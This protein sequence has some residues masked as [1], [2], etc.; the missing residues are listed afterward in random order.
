MNDILRDFP[1][2]VELKK[3]I[4]HTSQTVWKREITEKEIDRWLDNFTG[5]ILSIDEERVLALWLLSN[6]VYYNEDEVRHLCTV[7]MKDFVHRMLINVDTRH[8]EIDKKLSE[9][10]SKTRFLLLGKPSESGGYILYYF[11]TI[12]DLHISY[13]NPPQSSD[14]DLIDNLVFIDDVTL[15]AGTGGQAYKQLKKYTESYNVEGQRN[16]PL[17]VKRIPHLGPN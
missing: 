5:E 11:R 7:L 2:I 9:L 10:I 6:F 3:L 1:N 8:D 17:R 4:M 14:I 13:F 12:N 15:T 16:S